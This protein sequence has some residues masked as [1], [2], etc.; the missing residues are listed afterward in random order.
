MKTADEIY[1]SHRD[2]ANSI[3]EFKAI[4]AMKEYAK[5]YAKEVLKAAA[6]NAETKLQTYGSPHSDQWSYV[7]D[8]SSILNTPLPELK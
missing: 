5:E 3:T 4:E 7:I 8:R 2:R 6:D 1:K